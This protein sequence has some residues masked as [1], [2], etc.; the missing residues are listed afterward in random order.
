MVDHR[1][2]SAAYYY[3]DE[4]EFKGNDQWE[5]WNKFYEA[6]GTASSKVVLALVLAADLPSDEEIKRWLGE[7]IGLLII[8]HS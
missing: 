6:L 1:A 7:R 4:D 5:E 2:T 8:P 3:Q